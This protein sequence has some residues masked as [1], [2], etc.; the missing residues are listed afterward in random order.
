MG[1]KKESS[2]MML[3]RAIGGLNIME[4]PE[5]PT[6]QQLLPR[7][8]T[9]SKLKDIMEMSEMMAKTYENN[10]RALVAKLNGA[11]AMM[12]ASERLKLDFKRIEHESKMLDLEEMNTQ[13]EVKINIS[14]A[15]TAFYEA[16]IT[17][18]DYLRR[19]KEAKEEGLDIEDE[20]RD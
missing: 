15:E 9:K 17:K 19:T 10:T 4:P 2:M 6:N 7:K 16:K 18:L 20:D 8:F 3:A 12:T 1:E 11:T 5:I 14:R 13:A